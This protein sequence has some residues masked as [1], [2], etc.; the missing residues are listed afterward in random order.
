MIRW[1]VLTGCAAV[2]AGAAFVTGAT[3]PTGPVRAPAEVKAEPAKAVVVVG[4]KTGYF[5]MAKVMREYQRAKTAVVRLE[6]RK[7]RLVAN[8]VGLRAMHADLQAMHKKATDPNAKFAL[9]ND[10]RNV[11]RR[12]EDADRAISKILNDRASG[13]IAGLYDEMQSV[14]A[15]VARDNALTALLAYPDAVTP[16]EASNPFVKELKLKP[17]ALQPFY[18]DASADYSDE[19]VRRLN[20]KF[21]AENDE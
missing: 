21:A 15:A 2:V 14:A 3:T 4:Q 20:E 13:I 16:E 8:I 12:I 1:S 10:M 9:E 5:N 7:N 19:I 18:L 11:Q 17:P 6:E